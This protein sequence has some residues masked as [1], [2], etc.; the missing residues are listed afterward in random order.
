M[1]VK[2]STATRIEE[3][4]GTGCRTGRSEHET[5]RRDEPG[6]DPRPAGCGC[7][8]TGA[9]RRRRIRKSGPEPG[10]WSGADKREHGPGAGR[11]AGSLSPSPGRAATGRLRSAGPEAAAVGEG[12]RTGSGLPPLRTDRTDRRADHRGTAR[13]RC[14]HRPDQRGAPAPHR[15]LRCGSGRRS[16]RRAAL[17]GGCGARRRAG[18]G[19][20]A[21]TAGA[22]PAQ[23]ASLAALS[24]SGQASHP[25]RSCRPGLR[26]AT[27]GGTPAHAGGMVSHRLP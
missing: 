6:I 15:P 25:D 13:L 23:V 3:W 10:G 9:A 20:S 5:D 4:G 11:V 2:T 1:R 16:G 22:Q 24:S 14:S 7:G 18:R 21:V 27:S 8:P 19:Q 12:D 26:R 17:A